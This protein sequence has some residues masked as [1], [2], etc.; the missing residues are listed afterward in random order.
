MFWSAS[1]CE[2]DVAAKLVGDS[3]GIVQVDSTLAPWV[4]FDSPASGSI[5]HICYRFNGKCP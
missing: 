2:I 4:A 5:V 3:D 1:S